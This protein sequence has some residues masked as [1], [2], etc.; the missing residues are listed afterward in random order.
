[1]EG[2]HLPHVLT[3]HRGTGR[4]I[5]FACNYT[6]IATSKSARGVKIPEYDFKNLLAENWEDIQHFADVCYEDNK[7]TGAYLSTTFVVRDMVRIIDA[8]GEDGLLRYYGR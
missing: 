1:M 8:L 3:S 2:S 5:P 6:P 4:T 7:E